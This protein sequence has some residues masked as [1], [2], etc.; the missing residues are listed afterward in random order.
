MAVV[1]PGCPGATSGP[2]TASST[3]SGAAGVSSSRAPCDSVLD[4]AACTAIPGC[5]YCG[6][7]LGCREGNQS[8]AT[9]GDCQRD[10]GTWVYFGRDCPVAPDPCLA[11]A[12]CADCVESHCN[13]CLDDQSCHS[14][15]AECAISDA[16]GQLPGCPGQDAGPDPCLAYVGCSEC[17]DAHCVQCNADQSCRQ[18]ETLCPA[19]GAITIP[20][21]CPD[22]DAGEDPCPALAD[23]VACTNDESCGFCTDGMV[24]RRGDSR[25]P[26][27]GG[28]DPAA[29]RW[30]ATDCT[31]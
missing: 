5:G 25:G 27:V 3:S 31:P 16:V 8:A 1:M 29:W 12:S 6:E 18:S 10:A 30:L 11:H 9:D 13:Y 22:V 4:C 24:C 20:R 14:S 21:T 19:G 2:S 23:C 28:C 7:T 15:P 17:L 26:D